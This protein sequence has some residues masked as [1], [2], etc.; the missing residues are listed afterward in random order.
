MPKIVT[1]AVLVPRFTTIVGPG[2]N[3]MT[4]PVDVA[5]YESASIT[6][7]RGPPIGTVTG[8]GFAFLE[9]TDRS[10]W[11]DIP[12]T[13]VVDPGPARESVVEFDFSKRWFR[14]G[15]VLTGTNPGVTCWAQGFFVNRQP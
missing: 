15:L 11:A 14:I 7:W 3:W 2:H 1:P 10:A 12:G 4:L 9:S 13:V 5:A 6:V 8:F